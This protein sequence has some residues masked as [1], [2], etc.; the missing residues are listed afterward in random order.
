MEQKTLPT[1]NTSLGLRVISFVICCTGIGSLI[2]SGIALKLA[3]K[4]K[5]LYLESPEEYSNY[6]QTKTARTIAIIG[7]ILGALIT[8]WLI[9]TLIS[10]GNNWEEFYEEIMNTYNEAI[11][12][13]Q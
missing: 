6:S 2:L 10:I 5:K 4:D 12:D 11:E 3:N 1:S 8:L 9:L 13:A 7:L